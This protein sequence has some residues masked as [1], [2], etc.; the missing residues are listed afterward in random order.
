MNKGADGLGASIFSML[1]VRALVDAIL[2]ESCRIF[3]VYIFINQNNPSP[4][5]L[6]FCSYLNAYSVDFMWSVNY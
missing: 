3:S 4:S 5:S 1:F 2:Y 6:S